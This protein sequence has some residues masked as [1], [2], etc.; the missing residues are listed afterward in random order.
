[1]PHTLEIQNTVLDLTLITDQE[2]NG[3]FG[4]MGKSR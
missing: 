4:G 3:V 1:M 2:I